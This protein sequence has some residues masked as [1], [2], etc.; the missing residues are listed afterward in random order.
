MPYYWIGRAVVAIVGMIVFLFLFS[1][2]FY[3]KDGE[4]RAF[5]EYFFIGLIALVFVGLIYEHG[6]S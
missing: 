2:V 3:R 1:K 5:T 6:C 4:Y